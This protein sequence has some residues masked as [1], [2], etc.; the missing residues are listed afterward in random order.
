M[1]HV[2]IEIENRLAVVRIER[3]SARNALSVALIGELLDAARQLHLA[4]DVDAIVLTGTPRCFSAGADRK[5]DR[6]FRS[7]LHALDHWHLVEGGNE[8]AK[9]WE[10]LR[11]P[12]FAAIEGFAVGGG[13]TLAMACDFRILGRNAFVQVPE[14]P[15]GFNYGWNSIPRLVSLV[16][17]S[18]AKEVVIFG[19][20][21]EAEKCLSWGMADRVVDEGTA[22]DAAVAWARR[23]MA[24]P[25]I[26]VQ[27]TKR[28]VNAVSN[29]HQDIGS[30]AD[31]AQ[32]LLCL[33]AVSENR[34]RAA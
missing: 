20:K 7:E 18:K 27:F 19:D 15:L 29:A 28:S 2:K 26:A 13:F 24:L 25:Q 4:S 10:N 1:S 32:I 5:D 30:H 6:I 11:Q 21:I 33:R 31:M 14:V 17:P 34:E 9:A 22:L 16:G 8:T 23:A 12:T 3:E